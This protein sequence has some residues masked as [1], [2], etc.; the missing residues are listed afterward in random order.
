MPSQVAA[1]ALPQLV[2][3]KQCEQLS[4]NTEQQFLF[5]FKNKIKCYQSLGLVPN[6]CAASSDSRGYS[7]QCSLRK[8]IAATV[9]GM[10][11]WPLVALAQMEY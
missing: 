1:L 6:F 4:T 5:F 10:A 3:R 7:V 2:W 9:P 11:H 8:Y